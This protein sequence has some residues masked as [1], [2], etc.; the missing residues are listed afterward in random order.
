VGGAIGIGLGVAAA[1]I[2]GK[3]AVAIM[4]AWGL[5]VGSVMLVKGSLQ[6]INRHNKGDNEGAENAFRTIGSG[7]TASAL[8][9]FGLRGLKIGG[10]QIFEGYKGNTTTTTA[11]AGA[12]TVTTTKTS[13][14]IRG[15]FRDVWSM[16]KGKDTG[17]A[18]TML[19]SMGKAGENIATASKA[20]GLRP[21]EAIRVPT[22]EQLQ[23]GATAITN[24]IKSSVKDG[25]VAFAASDLIITD[26]AHTEYLKDKLNSL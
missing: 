16:F 26:H 6:A 15:A 11:N 1:R 5:A 10:K 22:S 23:A 3:P 20:M 21:G 4:G 13:T 25:S 19:N 2:F 8:S 18:E 17:A 14:G 7:T 24:G 9:F 12:E